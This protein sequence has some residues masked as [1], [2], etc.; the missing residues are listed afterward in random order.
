MGSVYEAIE[1]KMNRPVALKVLSRHLLGAEGAH[2]RFLREA[3]I[4]GKLTHPNLVKVFERGETGDLSFYSM[5]LVDGGS[6]YDVVRNLKRHGRDDT[7]NLRAGT[8]ETITWLMTQVVAAARGLDY[9]HRHGVVHR[10]IKPMNLLLSKDPVTVKVADFGLAIDADAIRL[11]KTGSV[12]GTVAYMPPEQIRG[13]THDVGA[14]SDVYALGVTLFE[15]LTLEL[16]FLAKTQQMYVSAVL[17]TQARSASRINERLSRDLDVVLGKAMEKAPRDRYASAGAFADDLENVLNFRPILARP[18]SRATRAMKWARRKPVHAALAALLTV[19]VPTVSLLTARAVKQQRTLAQVEMQALWDRALKLGREDR[20]SEALAPLDE[21]VERDPAN[22]TYLRV[23]SLNH[24][25]LA[26]REPDAARR[27]ERMSPAFADVSR[28]IELD[29]SQSWPYQLRALFHRRLGEAASAD[30]DEKAAL[31][32]R[33]AEPTPGELELDGILAFLSN[34]YPKALVIFSDAIRRSPELVEPYL[35]RAH[36][37]QVLGDRPRAMADYQAAA[38]LMPNQSFP[39]Y[40]LGRLA[41]ESGDLETAAAYYREVLKLAPDEAMVHAGL[42]D[43]AI[44]QGKLKAAAGD[45]EGA[46]QDFRRAEETARKALSLDPALTWGH[47]N[48]GTALME[49][50]RQSANPD[51]ERAREAM[52]HYEELLALKESAGADPSE[53]DFSAAIVNLCDGLIQMRDLKRALEYCGKATRLYPDQA[54][55][56]YNLAGVFALSGQAEQ[57]LTNLEQDFT[58]GDRDHEYLAADDW[59]ASLRGHPR[60]QSILR[61]MRSQPPS[62]PR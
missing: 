55:V 16:P 21:L 60:F 32:R 41:A 8:R 52:R 3:W 39:R 37:F 26:S 50:G 31:E 19:A 46:S 47:L 2:E 36:I 30:A 59:F 28:A 45:G 22:A 13:Q 62:G 15:L 40:N 48:L 56:F 57:A 54:D 14:R 10:D 11:T 9:A 44:R 53:G 12:L 17:T 58:L 33:R 51:P 34:D 61:R 42:A 6:L 49:A 43:L 20:P 4:A 24:Y 35:R 23:R 25:R 1:L 29:G 18:P 5:E 27:R 7:W 38:A